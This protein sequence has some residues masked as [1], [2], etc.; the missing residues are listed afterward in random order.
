MN[1]NDYEIKIP[2]F[3]SLEYYEGGKHM[4]LDIDFRDQIIYLNTMLVVAWNHPHGD[5]R[6]EEHEK[7]KIIKNVY[8]YL[9]IKR[10]FEN[11]ILE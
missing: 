9:A 3:Y 2:H 6:I 7:E 8:N 11:I 5:V 10:G 4:T 1:E